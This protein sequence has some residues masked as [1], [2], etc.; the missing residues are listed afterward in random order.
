VWAA[1]DAVPMPRV[2]AAPAMP[3]WPDAA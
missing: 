1:V 3:R 2:D